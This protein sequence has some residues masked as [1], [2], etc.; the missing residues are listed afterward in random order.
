VLPL[1][2]AARPLGAARTARRGPHGA[3]RPARRGAARHARRGT[4][5]T[6][7]PARHG[8]ARRGTARHGTARHGTAAR[9]VTELHT[10][11]VCGDQNVH[12]VQLGNRRPVQVRASEWP[13]ATPGTHGG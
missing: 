10:V 2:P 4:A 5:R 1:V 13:S 7:R 6:A 8:T 12:R 11:Q 3:A 9:R